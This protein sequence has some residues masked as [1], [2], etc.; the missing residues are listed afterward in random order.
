MNVF[1]NLESQ[2]YFILRLDLEFFCFKDVGVGLGIGR[3]CVSQL[4]FFGF[5]IMYFESKMYFER[6]K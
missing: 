2:L 5:G 6:E 1:F 3:D 4:F